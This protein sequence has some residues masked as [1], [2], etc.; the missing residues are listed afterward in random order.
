ME[1]PESSGVLVSLI[2][3]ALLVLGG[4]G[5][6]YWDNRTRALLW[7]C[8]LAFFPAAALATAMLRPRG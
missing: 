8:W 4:K 7:G 3:P 2:G 1:P 6:P 5:W